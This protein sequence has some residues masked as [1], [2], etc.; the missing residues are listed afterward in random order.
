[1]TIVLIALHVIVC[2]LLIAVILLQAGKGH[3]LSSSSFGAGG[4]AQNVFGTKTAD[5]LTKATTVAAILFLITSIGLDIMYARKSRSLMRGEEEVSQE[6]MEKIREALDKLKEEAKRQE[7]EEQARK[8][9]EGEP[10]LTEEEQI[11]IDEA[12]AEAAGDVLGA[13]EEET[14]VI[15]EKVEKVTDN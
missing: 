7:L 2:L 4:P 6:D 15:E 14:E 13:T 5:F 3:G 10:G 1:M 9:A 8:A 12:V 11:E